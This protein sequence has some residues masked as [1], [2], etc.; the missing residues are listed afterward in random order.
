[1]LQH[2]STSGTKIEVNPLLKRAVLPFF[3]MYIFTVFDSKRYK[4]YVVDLLF[5]GIKII[6]CRKLLFGIQYFTDVVS[7]FTLVV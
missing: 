1:M 4:I 6:A 3:E 2:Q 7:N 5:T